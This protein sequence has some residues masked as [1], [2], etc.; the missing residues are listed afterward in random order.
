MQEQVV[1]TP[2]KKGRVVKAKDVS[3]A[4]NDSINEKLPERDDEKSSNEQ[5]KIFFSDSFIKGNLFCKINWYYPGGAE[6]FPFDARMQYVSK[7]YPYGQDGMVLIDEAKNEQE[8]AYFKEKKS[9]LM[10]RLK[11]RYVILLRGSE[12]FH[13]LG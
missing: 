4:T 10:K 6:A 2:A 13:E 5:K 11:Y 9:P 12:V 3:N 1:K 8:A 7:C